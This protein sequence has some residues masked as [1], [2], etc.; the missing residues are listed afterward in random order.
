MELNASG[1]LLAQYTAAGTA[2]ATVITASAT[3]GLEL[4]KIVICNTTGSAAAASL[5][6]DNSGAGTF[7][8]TTALL[9]G[10]VIPANDSIIFET[11]GPNGGFH[12]G[13]A[14]KIGAADS[15][16]GSLT[17]TFYGIT[18]VAGGSASRK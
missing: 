4:T 6:H 14:G 8:A 15:G 18:P 17:F 13:K 10:K 12:I 3:L 9:F 7:D 16:S 1:S 5:F 11:N 2:A